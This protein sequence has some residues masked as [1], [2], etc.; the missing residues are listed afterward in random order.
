VYTRPY[1]V[2][3]T[4]VTAVTVVAVGADPANS[5]GT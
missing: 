4:A 5:P 1:A 2:V 3:V